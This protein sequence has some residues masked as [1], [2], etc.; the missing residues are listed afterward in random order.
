MIHTT[1]NPIE[2]RRHEKRTPQTHQP[3]EDAANHGPSAPQALRRLHEAD[4]TACDRADSA[5][6]ATDSD[7][8]PR[9]DSPNDAYAGRQARVTNAIAVI[10]RRS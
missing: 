8:Y 1:A 3:G 7:P 2:H 10:R 4:N 6:I 5:A 9:E